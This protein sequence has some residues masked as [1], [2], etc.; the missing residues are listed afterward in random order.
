MKYFYV[1]VL[2]HSKNY[3]DI[4]DR[5]GGGGRGEGEGKGEGGGGRSI[6]KLSVLESCQIDQFLDYHQSQQTEKIY[7]KII[8]KNICTSKKVN[9][10]SAKLF[11]K[12]L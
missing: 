9:F 11:K 8:N 6:G 1:K 10:G 2:F 3:L 12:S 5:K 7:F 4:K